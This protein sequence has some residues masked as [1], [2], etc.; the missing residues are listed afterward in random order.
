MILP[1]KRE[2]Q[3]V[4]ALESGK[5]VVWIEP[6]A[7]RGV[8]STLKLD[9]ELRA[10]QTPRASYFRWACPEMKPPTW[11]SSCQRAG[12]PWAPADSAG[13]HFRL[14]EAG[15]QTWWFHGRLGVGNL[16]LKRPRDAKTP[17]DRTAL[18][19]SGPTRIVLGGN[20]LDSRAANWKTD[21]SVLCDQQAL[22]QFTAVLD[23]GL[24]LIDVSGP[25][26]M[27]FQS[28]QEGPATHVKVTLSGS[29]RSPTPVHFEAHARVAIEG[30][31]RVPAIHPVDAIWTG[32]TTTIIVDPLR[33]IQDC[34]ELAGRRVPAPEEGAAGSEALVF[35]ASSPDSVAELEFRQPRVD[36][37]CLV[38]GRLLAGT[39]APVLEC[40]L[41][42]L[43]GRG[44]TSELD[45]DLPPS[46]IPDRVQ[47]SG[48]TE[49]L[50][51]NSTLQADGSTRMRVVLPGREGAPDDRVLILRA[52]SNTA[53]GRGPLELPRV[54]PAHT[55]IRDEVWVA[56]V[57]RSMSLIPTSARGLA[58]IDPSQVQ[59]LSPLPSSPGMEFR[60]ALAWRWNREN[61]EARV[62]REQAESE[63]TTEIRCRARVAQNGQR[64][65]VEG[66]ILLDS[67]GKPMATVPLWI[68]QPG[69]DLSAWTFRGGPELRMLSFSP[70][71]D[72]AR[73]GLGLPAHGAAWNLPVVGPSPT[74]QAR[75]EFK[76]DLPWDQRGAIPLIS[77]P[78]GLSPRTTILIE[79]P[80]RT[81]SR[82]EPVGLRRID[83]ATAERLGTSWR[84]D[85]GPAS[86][87]AGPA[88]TTDFLAHAFFFTEPGGS[89]TLTTEELVQSPP[90]GLIR[91]AC[92]TSL[93]HPR[94]PWV[95]RL[96]LLLHAEKTGELRFTLPASASLLQDPARRRG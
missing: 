85:K 4:G 47:W 50:A 69:K 44:L 46:W 18:W 14:L 3:A 61:A 53:P 22:A 28:T 72:Q 37:S 56:M 59:G 38:R 33:R 36:E 90:T 26:V 54:R 68:S 51:W 43:G 42:G 75:I 13:D 78:R 66:Q 64:L 8:T 30:R 12:C 48:L 87:G 20:R 95:N 24:E 7:S 2:H 89:L 52:T 21:W 58:W 57:D 67:G 9:W 80:F 79:T 19:V 84:G 86:P 93:L 92:L 62:D 39:A 88:S 5:S 17:R 77:A 49:S 70:L 40:E 76:A 73:S 96:R 74:G 71:D 6:A 81:R 45:I 82:V 1:Q 27:G 60:P 29:P 34:R 55:A 65:E 32:G 23:P 35:E 25:D 31:W 15:F 83:I 11:P 63:P 91:D 94:G 16:Q 10:R 41:I